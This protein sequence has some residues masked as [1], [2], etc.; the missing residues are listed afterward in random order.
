MKENKGQGKE[1]TRE[2]FEVNILCFISSDLLP[3]R[4]ESI[5]IYLS[6]Y[7]APCYYSSL[8]DCR[9]QF[10]RFTISTYHAI[11]F[12]SKTKRSVEQNWMST[13]GTL[14]EVLSYRK[15]RE[16]RADEPHLFGIKST[17]VGIRTC[18]L[19]PRRQTRYPRKIA[20]LAK[21]NF[22]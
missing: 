13:E 5:F 21:M 4:Y 11:S 18:G 22:L 19:A 9:L 10:E 7:L 12:F 1:K 16:L 15:Q 20:R 6:K 14:T 17:Q 8:D 2:V 3:V